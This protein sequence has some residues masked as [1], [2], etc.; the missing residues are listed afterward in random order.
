MIGILIVT[1]GEFGK[2]LKSSAELITGPIKNC[3]TISLE[4]ED[5][6]RELKIKVE[7]EL[8]ILDK[9]KGVIV[10]VDLIGGSPFNVCTLCLKEQ[11]NFRLISGLNLPMF[12]E[13]SMMRETMDLQHLSKHS[14]EAGLDSIIEVFP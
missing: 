3:S 6:I 9:G 8:K 7:N 10:L 4:R 14:K 11:K 2:A 12:I 1:H 13:C 5:D